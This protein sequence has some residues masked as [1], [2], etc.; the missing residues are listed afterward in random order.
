MNLPYS[1]EE[2]VKLYKQKNTDFETILDDARL[3]ELFIAGHNHGVEAAMRQVDNSLSGGGG[4][5]YQVIAQFR[6]EINS[7][8][9]Q[10]RV[11]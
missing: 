11:Y 10:L 9:S 2:A 1:A 3:K 4:H 5:Y 7:L 8:I 6:Q